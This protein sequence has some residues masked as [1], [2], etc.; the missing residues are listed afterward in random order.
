MNCK[1]ILN[2]SSEA[3]I[4]LDD[5][6]SIQFTNTFAN[7]IFKLN[8]I[9][10]DIN[11]FLPKDLINFI[12]TI[13]SDNIHKT[14]KN[15]GLLHHHFDTI[16][17]VLDVKISLLENGSCVL[18]FRDVSD[19]FS[20]I[21]SIL[22]VEGK[23]ASLVD[24]IPDLVISI[25][26]K[27]I[28]VSANR[29][30]R[31]VLG[32]DHTKMIG[33]KFSLYVH[34][35]DRNLFLSAYKN[36]I[37]SNANSKVE[38]R[39]RNRKRGFSVI[40][41]VF[42]CEKIDNNSNLVFFLGR[43]VTE[44]IN[45][46]SF[47][48]EK[49]SK[50]DTT[51]LYSKRFFQDTIETLLKETKFGRIRNFFVFYLDIDRFKEINDSLGHK[52]GDTI[53]K[54]IGKRLIKLLS[55]NINCTIARFGG[56]EFAIALTDD[57]QFINP[58]QICHQIHGIF[59]NPIVVDDRSLVLTTSIG[60]CIGDK[61]IQYP[62]DLIRNADI[63]MYEAKDL[64][65]GKSCV[66]ESKMHEKVF[67]SMQME[68]WLREAIMEENLKLF[69]QPIVSLKT[70]KISHVEALCRWDHKTLGS[71]PPAQFIQLAE[72]TGQIHSI[73]DWILVN[74]CKQIQRWKLQ[75][76]KIIPIAINLSPIQ[77]EDQNLPSIFSKC[78]KDYDIS[79]EYLH[80]ELTE[81]LIMSDVS[82]SKIVLR[83]LRDMGIKIFLDD[84]GSGFSSLNYL[85][86]FPIDV[87]KIDK[88]FIDNLAV[89]NNGYSVIS[90][91]IKMAA[92]LNMKVVAEGIENIDQ[93]NLL[94][95]LNCDYI[96]GYYISRPVHCNEFEIDKFNNLLSAYK[97]SIG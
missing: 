81:S 82:Y 34:K 6:F 58:L 45:Y 16:L 9:P 71:I 32:W 69:L 42:F 97:Y 37:E 74:S 67:N 91:I 52:T 15:Y 3:I 36:A 77:F 12:L 14:K 11:T 13:K 84:F 55:E 5:D 47:L 78:L 27:N 86:H 43:D 21:D 57:N 22:S 50:D 70:E 93:L 85:I 35:D 76:K 4:I 72:E 23:F 61:T 20:S 2:E 18:L 88:T 64:G 79:P 25:N 41:F 40:E 66:Y 19:L 53:L 33:R 60:V 28:V 92:N 87:I 46:D 65:R 83:Q 8:E 10:I 90:A 30:L 62:E 38:L 75:D 49:I 95:D 7:F 68:T 56:D 96:Q 31:T 26:E 89:G 94:K 59:K 80:V 44:R 1:E 63:A 54:I 29:S 73:G 48:L 17:Y 24:S 51:S 39:I